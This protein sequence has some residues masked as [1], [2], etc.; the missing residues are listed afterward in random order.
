[1]RDLV[2]VDRPGAIRAPFRSF[3]PALL[4]IAVG[5]S[6]LLVAAGGIDTTRSSDFALYCAGLAYL[7]AIAWWEIGAASRTGSG[8]LPGWL[9]PPALI[10]AWALLWIYL[11][12]T[13]AFFDDALFDD[14]AAEQGGPSLLVS[15]ILLAAVAVTALSVSYHVTQR[16]FGAAPNTKSTPLRSMA[17]PRIVG[18][19]LFSIAA[20]MLRVS[21]TGIAFGSDRSAWGSLVAADQWIGYVEDLRYLALALL[22]AHIVRHGNGRIWLLI[23]IVIEVIFAATSGFF[24]PFIWPVLVCV[25][26]AAA[27]DR[28]RPRHLAM[29]LVVT[30]ALASFANVVNTIREDWLGGIGASSSGFTTAVTASVTQWDGASAGAQRAYEKFFG[31]QTE[32]ASST[33]LIVALTPTIVP[34]EGIEKF[35]LLPINLIPRALWPDKP[36]LSR[37]QW[38]SVTYRGLPEDTASSSAMTAFGEGYMFSGWIGVVIAM[39]LA[40]LALGILHRQ[41]D[42]RS[43]LPVYL[44]LLPTILEIEP[45]LSSYLTSLVQRSVVFIVVFLVV[46]HRSRAARLRDVSE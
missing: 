5:L 31:R 40:G 15:G 4:A 3:G 32:V 44:A 24:K 25:G 18:L 1:M 28:V 11:P 13:V 34:Y 17:L 39:A 23:A 20:R 26:A 12:A 46:T 35:L 22:I 30:L 2:T 27:L 43:F 8:A 38:F 36:V 6:F 16:L 14:F 37:G 29:V 10:S 33:G 7:G 42:S 41:L 21:V 45:E 9:A 19:Y